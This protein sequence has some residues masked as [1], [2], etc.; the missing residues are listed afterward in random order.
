MKIGS[1]VHYSNTVGL[2]VLVIGFPCS[3]PRLL[4]NFIKTW[5][6]KAWE[7]GEGHLYINYYSSYIS[8]CIHLTKLT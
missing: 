3:R 2:E 1:T 6:V 8:F 7:Q 4:S 5:T